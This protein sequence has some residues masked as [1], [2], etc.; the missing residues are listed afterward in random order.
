MS[1]QIGAD[2]EV[3]LRRK[4][5]VVSAHGV[6]PGTKKEPHKV[7]EGAIQVDGMALE[8]N[9]DPV[10]TNAYN[11]ER[12]F[13]Q[14]LEKVIKQLRSAARETD[15][16]SNLVITPVQE[17]DP[18]YMAE[19]PEEARELG[20]D[21][22]FSAYTLQPNPRPNGEVSFRTASGHVHVGWG[23]DI[24]VESPDHM[25]ICADF[26]KL[27]DC[28]VGLYMTVIDGDNRRREL[29]GK[30]GA[31]RPKSY[32][33]EYRTPSNVW[34]TSNARRRN[35]FRLVG[36]A[37]TAAQR[38]LKP[39]TLAH[40]T[41]EELQKIINEGDYQK[42]ANVLKGQVCERLWAYDMMPVVDRELSLR[43]NPPKKNKVKNAED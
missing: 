1:F 30:A 19:Q 28:T 23:A 27:M 31:F 18:E 37:I 11:G 40:L 3:F 24:P 16:T 35:M 26:I 43:T 36:M 8:F 4:G 2:P 34:L 7:E 17:F 39:S 41:D 32:G 9:V 33:V 20:C 38:Q 13:A 22:D 29:Y 10:D 15:P 21:P 6:V 12:V 14:R 42:A 5:K 25:Q